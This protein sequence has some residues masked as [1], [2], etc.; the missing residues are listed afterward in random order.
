MAGLL[1]QN[2]VK[3]SSYYNET[4][5]E[6]AMDNSIYQQRRNE[7]LDK[8]DNG[9]AIIYSNELLYGLLTIIHTLIPTQSAFWLPP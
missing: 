3:M 7:L 8:L 5:R 1:R 9:I 4:Y 6:K 2:T